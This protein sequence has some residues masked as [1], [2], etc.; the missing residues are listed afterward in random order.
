MA[1]L[2]VQTA[3]EQKW[4]WWLFQGSAHGTGP[5]TL[6]SHEMEDRRAQTGQ[7]AHVFCPG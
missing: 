7:D 6:N 4:F 5:E 1:S 3:P 2:T